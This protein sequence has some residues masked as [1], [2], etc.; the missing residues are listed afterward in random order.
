MD[1]GCDNQI[2]KVGSEELILLG[3]ESRVLGSFVPFLPH[4]QLLQVLLKAREQVEKVLI[5]QFLT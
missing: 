5:S 3:T 2:R 4:F 1:L